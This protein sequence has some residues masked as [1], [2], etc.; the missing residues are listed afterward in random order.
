MGSGEGLDGTAGR[1]VP[2]RRDT[3]VDRPTYPGTPRWVKV[4][5]LI[6]IVVVLSLGIL[7]V[8]S[9]GNHGPNRHLPTANAGGQTPS[10]VVSSSEPTA[11]G[12]G[13]HQAPIEHDGQQP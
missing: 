7:M 1:A 5:G 3:L 13:K 10:S 6:G 12:A 8:A 4:F 11:S 2:E 9:G